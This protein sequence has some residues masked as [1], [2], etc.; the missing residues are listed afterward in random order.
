VHPKASNAVTSA[1]ERG[2]RS[3]FDLV[4]ALAAFAQTIAAWLHGVRAGEEAM[5][6]FGYNADS[7]AY[8]MTFGVLLFVPMG[9]CFLIAWLTGVRALRWVA[10]GWPL[11]LLGVILLGRLLFL[12]R[13]A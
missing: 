9:T 10:F 5:R 7:G 2:R 13:A 1:T 6:E 12:S 3:G 8:E 4:A 11:A